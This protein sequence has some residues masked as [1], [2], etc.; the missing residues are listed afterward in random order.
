MNVLVAEAR[1]PYGVVLEMDEVNDDL[2]ATDVVLVIG[3]N[4]AVI[5]SAAEEPASPIAAMPVLRV[6]KAGTVIVFR[7]SMKTGDAGVQN[8]LFSRDGTRMLFGDARFCVEDVLEALP[9]PEQ[10]TSAVALRP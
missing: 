3:A 5:S 4:D 10:R 8:P 1:V 9:K 7:R 6:W 2:A